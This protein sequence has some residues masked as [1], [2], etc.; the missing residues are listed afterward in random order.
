MSNSPL[1][2]IAPASIL[3]KRVGWTRR[4]AVFV[5]FMVPAFLYAMVNSTWVTLRR[6]GV[7]WRDTFYSL[8]ALR[9]RTVR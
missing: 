3:A 7:Q 2:L 8:E 4:C 1:M 6:G 9:T 5:P